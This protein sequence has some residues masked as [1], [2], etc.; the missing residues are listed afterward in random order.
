MKLYFGTGGKGEDKGT[1]LFFFIYF[2]AVSKLSLAAT[3]L[4]AQFC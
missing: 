2:A 1:G 3:S 4:P